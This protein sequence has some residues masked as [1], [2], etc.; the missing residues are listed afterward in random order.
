MLLPEYVQEAIPGYDTLKKLQ[1]FDVRRPSLSLC[2][3][4][5]PPWS[6]L[7]A[8]AYHAYAFGNPSVRLDFLAEIS[9][10]QGHIPPSSTVRSDGYTL[11]PSSSTTETSTSWTGSFIS[12]EPLPSTLNISDGRA[13]AMIESLRSI[14]LQG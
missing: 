4:P 3:H 13:W 14:C 2:T 11:Y 5:I 12:A 7:F 6:L 1:S 9:G 8:I 10:V